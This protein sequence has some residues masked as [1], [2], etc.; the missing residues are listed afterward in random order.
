MLAAANALLLRGVTSLAPECIRNGVASIDDVVNM[1]A[2]RALMRSSEVGGSSIAD[3]GG[4]FS[5]DVVAGTE[6][7]WTTVLP[8]NNSNECNKTE[9][10]QPSMSESSHNEYHLNEVLS[11]LPNLQHG[12]DVNPKFTL[13]PTGVEYTN[14]LAAFDYLGVE[15]VHGWLLDPQDVEAS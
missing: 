8:K 7:G 15:L 10:T 11:L 3:G 13:G 9:M 4:I 6:N 12:M 1:L 2:N 14:S 5:S